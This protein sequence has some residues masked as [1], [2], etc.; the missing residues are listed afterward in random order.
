MRILAMTILFCC[1]ASATSMLALGGV[2]LVD[3]GPVV[4]QPQPFSFQLTQKEQRL[5]AAVN[6]YRQDRGLRALRVSP[7][8]METARGRT[9]ATIRTS[10]H[11]NGQ[12]PWDAAKSHG[13]PGYATENLAW[14]YP[15]P[16]EA[17]GQP[18]GSRG[19]WQTSPGHARA[20]KGNF[21]DIGVGVR[22]TTYVAMF[23]RPS[24]SNGGR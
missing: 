16:E 13:Y 3:S 17:V 12:W 20:M 22:G 2:L 6:A 15:S 19:G 18:L 14:G 10:H 7:I 11:V 1:A 21:S 4:Q 8:L 9:H 24:H 23:G 5:V